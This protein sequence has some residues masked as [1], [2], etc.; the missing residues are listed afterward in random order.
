MIGSGVDGRVVTVHGAQGVAIEK[1]RS[2]QKIER[3]T[4]KFGV[5]YGV[6]IDDRHARILVLMR[7]PGKLDP[8]AKM[9]IIRR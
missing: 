3:L 9:L 1:A 4:V 6:E 8:T 5:A 2:D 7:W